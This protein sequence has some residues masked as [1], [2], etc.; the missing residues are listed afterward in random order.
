[1]ANRSFIYT[2][3]DIQQNR[4]KACGLSEYE[5]EVHPL[6]LLMVAVESQLIFS[7]VT[8]EIAKT[9]IVGNFDEGKDLVCKFLELISTYDEAYQIDAF[10][11]FVTETKE[12]LNQR[13][14]QYVVLE[15]F[16]IVALSGNNFVPDLFQRLNEIKREVRELCEKHLNGSLSADDLHHLEFY[17][18][19]D[20]VCVEWG[21]L[22]REDID[23]TGFW[24]ET[25]Y[26]NFQ[27]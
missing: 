10:R 7:N 3:E 16:E 17:N 15:N 2:T 27:Q 12:I 6:Y 23:W 9:A 11:V 21:E 22:E 5:N 25:L 1:M 13:N 20:D 14:V 24:S 18:D 4:I 19:F 8:E 26:Y